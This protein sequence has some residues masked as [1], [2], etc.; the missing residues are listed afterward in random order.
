MAWRIV[1][2]AEERRGAKNKA[3]MPSAILFC[4]MRRIHFVFFYDVVHILFFIKQNI[5][6][7]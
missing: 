2:K 5:A 6:A 4:S 7:A 1:A 3:V